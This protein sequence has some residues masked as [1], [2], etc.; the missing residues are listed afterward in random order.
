MTAND[1]RILILTHCF[2]SNPSDIPG[3]FLYELC[4]SLTKIG[5]SVTVM[6]QRMSENRDEKFLK[7]S[8]AEIIY[9]DWKG[10]EERFS[11]MK[12]YSVKNILSVMSLIIQG[13]KKLRELLNKNEFDLV[14]N[15][16]IVPSGF[17]SLGVGKNYKAAFWALG[18]DISVYARKFLFKNLIKFLIRKTDH[19]FTNSRHNMEEIK[20]LINKKPSMLYTSRTLPAPATCYKQEECLKLVF[21]GRLEKIKGPDML[22]SAVIR[23]GVKNIKLTLIGDGSMR[24]CLEAMVQSN[25]LSENTAFLGSRNA[26]EISDRLAESDYLVISSR[27][28]SMP[29]VFWEAMQ[30]STPVISTDVGDIK[31]Y[32][33]E[34]NVG[35]TCGADEISLSGLLI[36]V[37][38][39]RPLRDVLS[40]NTH[41]LAQHANISGSAQI[42]YE[43]C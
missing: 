23:S 2:P 29:V 24:N 20:R 12:L 7:A 8:G 9:F 15:C 6:T 4:I 25:G 5:V 18:S 22:I 3:N 41:K 10:G 39:F 34:F 42:L 38:D 26:S 40:E 36:F 21:V 14:L 11:G 30:T 28:E 33:D 1:K 17:W 19:I 37:S 27:E 43:L 31:Y 32:C 16:W 35:R 13:R